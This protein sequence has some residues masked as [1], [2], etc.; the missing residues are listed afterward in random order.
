MSRY[1]QLVILGDCTV[2][3]GGTNVVYTSCGFKVLDAAVL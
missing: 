3:S 2:V 1:V